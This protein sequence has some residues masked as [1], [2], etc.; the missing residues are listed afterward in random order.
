MF[1]ERFR[2]FTLYTPI[3]IKFAPVNDVSWPA[4]H[5]GKPFCSGKLSLVHVRWIMETI[6]EK[7]FKIAF[8]S[9]SAYLLMSLF[10]SSIHNSCWVHIMC[11]YGPIWSIVLLIF[12]SEKLYFHSILCHRLIFAIINFLFCDQEQP[13]LLK[14]YQYSIYLHPEAI[15]TIFLN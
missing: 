8:N 9:W 13:E 3:L 6:C 14:H 4:V 15:L 5:Y 7:A 11:F 1:D 10:H 12:C 2:M